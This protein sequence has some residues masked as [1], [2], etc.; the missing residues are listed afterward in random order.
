MQGGMRAMEII[1]MEVEREELGAVVTGVIRTC[2]SPLAGDGLDEAFGLAI[3][4]GTIGSGEEMFEPELAA[5][6]GEEIGAI[7]RAL[8]GEDGLDGDAVG[9]VKGQ[10]L[11]ECGQD[12]GSFFIRKETGKGEAGMIINGDV[13]AFDPRAWIAMRTVAGGADA[14]VVEAAKLFNIKMKE[15]A[16]SGAFVTDD[17]RLGRFEGTQAVETMTFEDAGKGSF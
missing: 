17:R 1:V 2:V 3:G 12:A 13:Q 16:G 14:G 5:G 8:V 15:F 10:S 9:L 11:L 7:G 4:L 6:G